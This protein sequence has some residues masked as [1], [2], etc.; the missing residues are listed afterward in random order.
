MTPPLGFAIPLHQHGIL[1][2]SPSAPLVLPTR[3]HHPCRRRT[4]L[5]P[6]KDE[7]DDDFLQRE[8][9]RMD[10]L[11]TNSDD[12]DDDNNDDDDDDVWLDDLFDHLP[13]DA[14]PDELKEMERTFFGMQLEPKSAE[15]L[16]EALRQGVVPADA[17]VGSG[18]L[19]GDFGF[20]PLNF[21]DKDYIGLVQRFIINLIPGE[22]D[23]F[24]ETTRP[25]ALILR[26]YREAE[27]R[28][29]RL[30]MLAAVFWPLQEMTDRFVLD[31][32]QFSSVLGSLFHGGMTLPYI[33]L[34][35]TALLL[36]LG[37]LD[38]YSKAVKEYEKVGEAFAPGDCFW[39]P[40]SMLQ[41]APSNMK[42]N[43]QER[44]LLN[45]RMAM[46][47]VGFYIY[48]EAIS[49]LALIEIPGN[50]LL[51]EPLYQV[52]FVQRWLDYQFGYYN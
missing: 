15:S 2:Q 51:F 45:G 23:I 29:G 40:L 41:G 46:L 21:A 5:F 39:D 16:E 20:D 32:D 19:P 14:D 35:M 4:R 24:E 13:E 34:F 44:E 31:Q 12:D 6:K 8:W 26:D 52:P 50:E 11:D 49:G 22:K 36:L 27:I 1:A 33:P 18:S 28:H 25:S 42:R 10:S 38:I 43:M 17:G 9:N 7:A 30:A 48:E 3:P 37:Y 47:G